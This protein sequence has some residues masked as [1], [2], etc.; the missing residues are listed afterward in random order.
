MSR[1][2]TILILLSILAVSIGKPIYE[3]KKSYV[4]PIKKL[5]YDVNL[6]KGRT[7]SNY[8]SIVHFFKY[9]G[10]I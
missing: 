5:N 4:T 6:V 1:S 8:V 10:K 3:A 2:I 9:N 7:N